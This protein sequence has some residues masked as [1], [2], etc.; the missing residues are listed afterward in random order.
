MCD[1]MA[2]STCGLSCGGIDFLTDSSRLSL[3]MLFP[4]A[5]DIQGDSHFAEQEDDGSAS[6]AYKGQGDSGIRDCVGDNGDI[7]YDL[8]CQMPHDPGRQ[9]CSGKICAV[10]GDDTES[11]EQQTKNK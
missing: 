9:K 11:P 8:D 2:G 1:R 5:A 4:A 6:V 3:K 10:H 7:Q